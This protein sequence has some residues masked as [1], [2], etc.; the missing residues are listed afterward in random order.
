MRIRIIGAIIAVLLAVAGTLAVVLYVQGADQRAARGAQLVS[1][2]VVKDAIAQG[3]SGKSIHDHIEVLRIARN[4]AQPEP[5]TSLAEI[6]DKVAAV[7]LLPGEQLVLGRFVDPATLAQ[8]GEVPVPKGLQ[9]V[10]LALPVERVVG[11]SVAAG[12]HVGIVVTVAGI[13]PD[14]TISSPTTKFAFENVLVT[15][16]QSGDSYTAPSDNST[17]NKATSVSVLMVT[18]AANTPD[19]ERLIWAA[20]QQSQQKAGIWLT[21]QT[22]GTDRSGSTAVSGSNVFG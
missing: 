20:E 6:D 4:A 5:V 3:A 7:D 2:Y 15:K 16:V 17:A 14:G 21:L 10:T 9:Q 19:V 13:A 1:V 12:S 18:F 22:D 8:R 11:G